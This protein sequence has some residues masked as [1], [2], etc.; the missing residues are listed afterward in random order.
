MLGRSCVDIALFSGGHVVST[1]SE[2]HISADD[3]SSELCTGVRRLAGESCVAQMLREQ[4]SL[5]R[6]TYLCLR[7]PLSMGLG[8]CRKYHSRLSS[9]SDP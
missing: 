4:T 1:L 3:L 5:I 8:L 2:G 9:T 6:I 7:L